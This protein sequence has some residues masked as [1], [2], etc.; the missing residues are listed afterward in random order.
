MIAFIKVACNKEN[1]D[2]GLN[3][4]T[5]YNENNLR[6]KQA[7]TQSLEKSS[8]NIISSTLSKKSSDSN[9]SYMLIN[10]RLFS[11]GRRS[12]NKGITLYLNKEEK[13]KMANN[14]PGIFIVNKPGEFLADE[15]WSE[16]T[17]AWY[18]VILCLGENYSERYNIS[19]YNYRAL[20]RSTAEKI[21]AFFITEKNLNILIETLGRSTAPLKSSSLSPLP[22]KSAQRP[23]NI[24]STPLFS[25]PSLKL[26]EDLQLSFL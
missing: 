17:P 8:S 4:Y 24:E 18:R 23:S 22:I 15:S 19:N 14:F 21:K 5:P 16:D 7:Y 9:H 10:G 6:K 3:F 11:I 13:S 2:K 26:E 12:N 1:L 25:K 20:T